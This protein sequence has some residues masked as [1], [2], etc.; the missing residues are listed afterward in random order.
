MKCHQKGPRDV[1]SLVHDMSPIM[2]VRCLPPVICLLKYVLQEFFWYRILNNASCNL[3]FKAVLKSGIATT[4]SFLQG[5]Y[6]CEIVHELEIL[7]HLDEK[8]VK[9]KSDK[10][11]SNLST[12]IFANVLQV[13]CKCLFLWKKA[14]VY[15]LRFSNNAKALEVFKN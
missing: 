10:R 2:S 3:F 1:T 12:Y 13:D 6:F 4:Q 15:L 8:S 7:S 14:H 9:R 5:T 11:I